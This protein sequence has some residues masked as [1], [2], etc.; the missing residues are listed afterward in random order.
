MPLPHNQS[1]NY[2]ISTLATLTECKFDISYFFPSLT[3]YIHLFLLI[4]S[5]TV[6]CNI[7]RRIYIEL[8][9][10]VQEKGWKQWEQ[11]I[12]RLWFVS[13][14]MTLTNQKPGKQRRDLRIT[15]RSGE[16]RNIQLQKLGEPQNKLLSTR[17]SVGHWNPN[18]TKQSHASTNSNTAAV[19]A[20][21]QSESKQDQEKGRRAVRT[22]FGS[23]EWIEGCKK[24]RIG[25]AESERGRRGESASREGGDERISGFLFRFLGGR[26]RQTGVGYVWCSCG[27][28]VRQPFQFSSV[29]V[30]ICSV[31]FGSSDFWR[32]SPLILGRNKPNKLT[33]STSRTSPQSY[34]LKVFILVLPSAFLLMTLEN[35]TF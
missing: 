29:L 25:T 17:G 24:L 34:L 19:D 3:T 9:A 22:K 7:E 26:R 14:L 20:E 32:I 30:P 2:K 1:H 35:K 28:M 10:H 6:R 31:L 12:A 13:H 27:Y 15:K 33:V 8:I 23:S 5:P 16:R 11:K 18:R 21:I 4:F